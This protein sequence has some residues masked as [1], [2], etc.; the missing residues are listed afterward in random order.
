MSEANEFEVGS[1]KFRLEPLKLK[2]SQKGLAIVLHAIL[3]A[4]LGAGDG[5][6]D[7]VA[8]VEGVDR[9]PELFDIFAA[10]ATVLWQEQG[11]MPLAA[12][13]DNVFER[14]PD[15]FIGFVAECVALEYA[16][17]L[18]G[19]GATVLEKA[20]SRFSSLTA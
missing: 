2:Q 8:V 13:A 10:K 1:W 3:P 5:K 6:I 9:L 11:Y 17:F 14:R 15:L 20:A 7:P 12:M 16:S 4:A 19:S 18:N